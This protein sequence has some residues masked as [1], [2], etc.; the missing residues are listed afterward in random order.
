VDEGRGDSGD[1]L[2]AVE[3]EPR[4]VVPVL[5][6]ALRPFGHEPLVVQTFGDDHVRHGQSQGP[7]GAG[8]HPEV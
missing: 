3:G 8:A 6:K 1:A 7:V 2:G 5:V 4:N